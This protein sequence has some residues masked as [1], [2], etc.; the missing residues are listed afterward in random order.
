MKIIKLTESQFQ[1]VFE[2]KNIAPSFTDGDLKEYPGSEISTSSYITSTNGE[3]EYG[4]EPTTD[5]FANQQSTQNYYAN[6]LKNSRV[7]NLF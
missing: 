2:G 4:V 7:A 6:G 3:K 5:D 1:R